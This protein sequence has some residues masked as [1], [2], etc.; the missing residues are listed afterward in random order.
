MVGRVSRQFT[1]QKTGDGSPTLRLE[2][3]ADA[4]LVSLK[5]LVEPM[6]NLRGALSETDYIY[7]EA[8]RWVISKNQ[9]LRL[10][11]VGLGLGYIEMMACAQTIQA[12]HKEFHALSFEAVPE[13]SAYLKAWLAK[14]PMSPEVAS[15]P[16]TL[17]PSKTNN[18]VIE[19][20]NI[21]IEFSNAYS[22]ILA[23]TADLFGIQSVDLRARLSSALENKSWQILGE[24]NAET[25]LDSRFNFISFDAF[26]GETTPELWTEDFLT[27]LISN[28]AMPTASFATYACTSRLNRALIT[29]HFKLQKRKGYGYKRHCTLATREAAN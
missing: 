29:N 28:V 3:G 19:N 9:E 18:M 21:P 15:Q 2:P 16:V 24:L 11:S 8:A 5:T 10:F 25:R 1:F 13:L 26:S 27:R 20:R 6:H 17:A 7:G 22:Q 23:M 4:A 12:G 14:E